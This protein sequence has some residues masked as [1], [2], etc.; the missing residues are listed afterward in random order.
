MD[1]MN[2]RDWI[3]LIL[4]LG[5]LLA[6]TK[7]LGLYM[8]KVFDGGKHFFSPL[9]GPVERFF[10]LALGV[11]PDEDQHWTKYA[12]NMLIFSAVGLLI[13]YGILRIQNVLPL[14]PAAMGVIPP[15]LAFNTAMSF[16]TNTNWQSYGGE[17][18]MSYFSQMVALTLHNFTSAAVGISV[19]VALI[20]GLARKQATGIGN[21]WVDLIRC[22]L[23][24]LLP[25]CLLFAFFLIT[26]GMIQ[27]FHPYVDA[28]TLEG[29]KQT[30]AQGPVASQVAIKML[31]TNGGGFFNTNAAHPFENP[32]ALSNFLQMLS[33]FLIPSGLVYLLGKKVGNTR[34]GWAVWSAMAIVFI[35]GFSVCSHYEF[36]GNPIYSQLGCSSSANME[37]KETRFGI[38]NSTLF[39]TITTDASCGAVNSMH[40]SYTPLGGLVPLVN[41][42]LGEVIFGGVGSGLYG[43]LMYI[44]L[45]VFIA[46]LMVGRT[47]EY[48]GKKIEGR[49]VKYVTFS[50]IVMALSILGFTAWGALDSAALAGLG[51]PAGHGF[52]EVLY[53]YTSATGN[54]GSAFAGLSTN[55]PF[56]NLTLAFAMFF[57]RFFMMI[58]MLAVAGSMAKKRIHPSGEGTFPVDG[59]L[60]VGLLIGVIVLIGALTFFPALSLGPIAEHF[61][62]LQGHFFK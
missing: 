32:T 27:N 23:Y 58:P 52:T 13:T 37:G 8:E 9:L 5:I 59:A 48:V 61:D 1:A 42:M 55:T 53:A 3:Q 26:Q 16:T 44:I 20:R 43:M 34:H 60:F 12:L 30:I 10:Y 36:K 22:N 47:P 6:A 33:I 39:A 15:H 29:A 2:S 56:W 7:P 25:I 51:N 17:S 19:A 40:D 41:V 35:I 24:I 62:M 38:F 28:L 14:N 4:F 49:E 50:L 21:F 31:G 18:T 46:G 57:G 11:D 45:T 54:N